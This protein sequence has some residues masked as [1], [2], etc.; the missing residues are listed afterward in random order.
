MYVGM[1]LKPA[2][3]SSPVALRGHSMDDSLLSAVL[4]RTLQQAAG[5]GG[6]L[7]VKTDRLMHVRASS[8][9]CLTRPAGALYLPPIAINIG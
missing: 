2:L 9:T 4:T 3:L 7:R 6:V 1:Q 8:R 5:L